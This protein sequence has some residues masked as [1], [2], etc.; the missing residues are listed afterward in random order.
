MTD[1]YE[2]ITCS[3]VFSYQVVYKVN[4]G[5]KE[6]NQ[7]KPW[8]LNIQSRAPGCP[9]IVVGTHVDQ[10]PSG[11]LHECVGGIS[12]CIQTSNK[13]PMYMY[14]HVYKLDIDLTDFFSSV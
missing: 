5:D 8:L 1:C 10:L 4:G 2:Q 9:V 3:S 6:I 14:N 11:K 13:G 12:T 7:L